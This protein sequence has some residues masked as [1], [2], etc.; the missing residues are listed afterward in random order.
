MY[1]Y[2]IERI[3]PVSDSQG[4][5]GGSIGYHRSKKSSKVSAAPAFRRTFETA[6][7]ADSLNSPE[8]V[9]VFNGILGL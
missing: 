7:K 9:Q 1:V 8:A 3:S 2:R 5:S 4:G 6:V